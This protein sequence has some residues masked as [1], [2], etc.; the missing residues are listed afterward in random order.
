MYKRGEN[1]CHIW[2]QQT[3]ST[4][5]LN[6]INNGGINTLSFNEN[7]ESGSDASQQS[8]SKIH[9]DQD[10]NNRHRF[11]HT[12]YDCLGCVI[13]IEV[14]S[15]QLTSDFRSTAPHKTPSPNMFSVSANQI[16]DNA[17]NYA[18]QFYETRNMCN[19]PD[20]YFY[21]PLSPDPIGASLLKVDLP[22][23]GQQNSSI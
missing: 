8:D 15:H 19:E 5:N 11:D 14:N 6:P 3:Y 7:K 20:S 18:Y 1:I 10:I 9:I 16:A 22:T 2:A 23:K 17:A 4:E 12:M 21:P 13:I